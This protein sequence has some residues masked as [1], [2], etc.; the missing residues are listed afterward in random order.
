MKAL[1][2]VVS[3]KKIFENWIS[4]TSFDPVTNL[5]DWNFGRGP[6][7]DPFCEVL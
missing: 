1:G 2:I 7:M 6:P 3:D 5:S 4:K